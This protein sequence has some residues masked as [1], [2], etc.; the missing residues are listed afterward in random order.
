MEI[1]SP[2]P[3]DG[4]AL[5]IIAR[6]WNRA[7]SHPPIDLELLHHWIGSAEKT[8]KRYQRPSLFR[9]P[10]DID[11]TFDT[12]AKEF[13]FSEISSSNIRKAEQ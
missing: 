6:L 5:L 4:R 8:K 12:S 1:F 13:E 9:K 7:M 2:N 10:L 3:R 11:N